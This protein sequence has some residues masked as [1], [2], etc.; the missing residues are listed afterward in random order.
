MTDVNKKLW[1]YR[2]NEARMESKEY[3]LESKLQAYVMKRLRQCKEIKVF[4]T[5]KS[6]EAGVSDI[7]ACAGGRYI[8]IEL[9]VKKNKTTP[10]QK[11]FLDEI[12]KAGGIA[13]EARTWREV[14][15]VFKL[16][17]YNLDEYFENEVSSGF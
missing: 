15:D 5:I 11:N 12:H 4:K 3:E 13:F 17:G 10:L 9:K 8:A 2:R 16:A 7:I 1:A 14:K 6:N